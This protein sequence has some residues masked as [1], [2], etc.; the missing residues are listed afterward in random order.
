MSDTIQ[1]IQCYS[2]QGRIGVLIELCLDNSVTT[3]EPEFIQLS[4]DLAMHVA[5]YNPESVAELLSQPFVRESS[6]RVGQRISDVSATL[7][8]HITVL[9]FLRWGDDP[10]EPD[11]PRKGPAVLRRFWRTGSDE[12]Q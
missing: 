9:R 8:E 4:L 6:I 10:I 11:D 2:H 1:Y 5:A 3:R 12:G 7:E